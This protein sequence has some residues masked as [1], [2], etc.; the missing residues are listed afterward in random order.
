M[1]DQLSIMRAQKRVGTVLDNKWRLDTL[2]GIGGSGA[3]YAATHRNTKR[4]AVKIL[5]PELSVY[6]EIVARFVR[7]GYVANKIDHPSA[8]AVLDDDR[9]TDGLVYLVMELLDGESLETYTDSNTP[10]L[11]LRDVARIVDDL[12]DVL[13]AAHAHGIVHRDIKPANLFLTRQG[14]LKVLDFG[15]ARLAEPI[16]GAIATQTGAPIGTPAYMPPEQARGRWEAVDARTDVWAAGATMFALL[17][18]RSPRMAETANE[19]L[20]LAM[21]VP[22]EPLANVAKG[23]PIN[24]ARV[25]DTALALDMQRR[26]PDARAMQTALREAMRPLLSNARS[27]PHAATRPAQ[28][29]PLQALPPPSLTPE[30]FTHPVRQAAAQ[31]RTLGSGSVGAQH[32]TG[33]SLLENRRAATR[34]GRGW[35]LWIALGLVVVGLGAGL[36]TL[37]VMR[38]KTH[39]TQPAATTPLPGLAPRPSAT[40]PLDSSPAADLAPSATASAPP[41]ADST[42]KPAMTRPLPNPRPVSPAGP[43]TPRPRHSGSSNAD[44]FDQ[45]F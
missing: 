20:L 39:A 40:P 42:A 41:S 23:V 24:I 38:P 22:V 45:R 8:V 10:P 1:L 9:A 12:L 32:T 11:S 3:V 14:K 31:A 26:W 25:V 27:L 36:A 21:T 33:P 29:S 28:L 30:P 44:P 6:P 2:L 17:T 7:E 16:A 4:A 37:R 13:A 19:E 18:Q 34:T 43:T 35:A 5:H 15:I